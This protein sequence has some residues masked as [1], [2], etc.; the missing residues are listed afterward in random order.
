MRMSIRRPLSG[1][2]KQGWITG[3]PS[4]LC[5]VLSTL[6]LLSTIRV[7]STDST[8]SLQSDLVRSVAKSITYVLSENAV[9]CRPDWL[10]AFPFSNNDD[11]ITSHYLLCLVRYM[12]TQ[13]AIA[14]C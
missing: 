8:D 13:E 3:V 14:L 10:V 6:L 9:S 11:L 7:R 2:I 4:S 1:L 5:L 12:Y